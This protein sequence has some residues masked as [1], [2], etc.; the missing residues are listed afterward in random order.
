MNKKPGHDRAPGQTQISVSMPSE[1]FARIRA[2]AANDG[3]TVS[4][5]MREVIKRKLDADDARN[6]LS[7]AA[8]FPAADATAPRDPE[9]FRLNEAHDAP[10]TSVPTP[11]APRITHARAAL[12]AVAKKHPPTK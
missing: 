3:R 9:N 1:L 4:N 5:W 2:A 6:A 8:S 7:R 11:Q 10:A 12:R